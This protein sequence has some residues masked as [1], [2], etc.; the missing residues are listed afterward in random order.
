M[1]TK[2]SY[3]N[4]MQTRVVLQNLA[5]TV[6]LQPKHAILK[7]FTSRTNL[8]E[9]PTVLSKFLFFL[10]ILIQYIARIWAAHNVFGI[11]DTKL[12]QLTQV[13]FE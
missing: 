8:V 5:F 6:N 2:S 9:I 3:A 7:T 11:Y 13:L 12:K 1:L 4:Q 10:N